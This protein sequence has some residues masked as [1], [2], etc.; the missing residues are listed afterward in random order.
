MK[1]ILKYEAPPPGEMRRIG[2]ISAGRV[3]HFARQGDT[4][5]FWV[6]HESA[7]SLGGRTF[8]TVATGSPYPDTLAHRGT[9]IDGPLV[10]HLMEKVE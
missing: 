9:L 1:R 10:W 3:V 6:E 5:Q 8:A 4:Y 2:N 7:E